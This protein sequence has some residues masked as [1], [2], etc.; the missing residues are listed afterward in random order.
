MFRVKDIV[1]DANRLAETGV[2]ISDEKAV[3]RVLKDELHRKT[4]Q[5]DEVYQVKRIH[6]ESVDARKVPVKLNYIVDVSI[7]GSDKKKSEQ[8]LRKKFKCEGIEVGNTSQTPIVENS[9]DRPVIIGFG[10]CGMFAALALAKVGLK[11]IVIERGSS[12]AKRDV[13]VERFWKEGVLDTESNVQF[14]EGG[15]GSYSDGKLTSRSKDPRGHFVLDTLHAFGAPERITYT[16][17]PHVGTDLLKECVVNLRNEIIHLG[18]EI[19]FDSKFIGFETNE[20]REINAVSYKQKGI[21]HRLESRQVVLAIG[22]SARDTFEVLLEKGVVMTQ[23]PFAVGMRIEHPQR[24]IDRSQY[25]DDRIFDTLGAADYF[26]THQ[27]SN[28]R[29]VYTFCMCPGGMVVAA[30]SEEGRLVT[31]GMSYHARDTGVANS[32]LLVNVRTEDFGSDHPLAGVEFQRR[33]EEKAYALGGGGYVA[34]IQ[35]AVDYITTVELREVVD[36]S[37][38][39]PEPKTTYEPGTKSANLAEL[40]PDEFNSAMAEGLKAF[41]K[42]IKG[43]DSEEA[44]LTAVESRT[45]SPVR[46]QRG[47]DLES[48]SIKGLYPG[49]EGAGYAGGIVSSAI[50]GIRIAETIINGYAVKK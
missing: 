33:L 1:L 20:A 16:S 28:G 13:D 25:K 42:K 23:K 19:H 50:D 34:P 24:K 30:A 27:A 8:A 43:F 22:H 9:T 47:D 5:T 12:M 46:I 2:N 38:C 21:E 14:G 48:T 41:G 17:K 35:K 18:G 45:S 10:P 49:G 44:V 6:K 32:A 7:K 3:K 31:N 11:P 37:H 29:S 4:G 39:R 26:V 15:A 40:F 36:T